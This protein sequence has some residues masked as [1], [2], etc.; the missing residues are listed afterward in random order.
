MVEENL[1]ITEYHRAKA[2]KKLT[3]YND[4]YAKLLQSQ[5]VLIQRWWRGLKVR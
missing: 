5:I 3:F 4:R 2:F 1:K